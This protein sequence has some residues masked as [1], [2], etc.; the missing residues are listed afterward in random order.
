MLQ[1]CLNGGRTREVCARVPLT[2]AEIAAE[3]AA[4]VAAVQAGLAVAFSLVLTAGR[5]AVSASPAGLAGALAA[6]LGVHLTISDDLEIF[7]NN[8]RRV[9]NQGLHFIA[10]LRECV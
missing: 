6:V 9:R 4:A 3:A 10:V 5:A 1:A 2:P 8:A 7:I